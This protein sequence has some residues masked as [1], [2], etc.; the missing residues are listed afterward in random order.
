MAIDV[1]DH[2]TNICTFP[3]FDYQEF[4]EVLEQLK[5]EALHPKKTKKRDQS[6]ERDDDQ[7]DESMETVEQS[8]KYKAIPDDDAYVRVLDLNAVHNVNYS[9]NLLRHLLRMMNAVALEGSTAIRAPQ[10]I[11]DEL[12]DL[13]EPVAPPADLYCPLLADRGKHKAV[14]YDGCTKYP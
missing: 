12:D 7:G 5:R 6:A 11:G 1:S 9:F 8:S 4:G 3:Q 2:A 13:N 10:K 14:R